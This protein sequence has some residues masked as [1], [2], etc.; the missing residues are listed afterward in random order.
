MYTYLYI[1]ITK[2]IYIYVYISIYITI[3]IYICI[4]IYIYTHTVCIHIYIVYHIHTVTHIY[5]YMY[6][7]YIHMIRGPF[8]FVSKKRNINFH[9]SHTGVL[10][11]WPISSSLT[12]HVHSHPP[13]NNRQSYIPLKI[14]SSLVITYTISDC[15]IPH[16]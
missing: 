1:C 16:S 9:I 12:V 13:T 8:S 14:I 7:S 4:H 11:I 3:Y 2:Y 15:C 6:V 5:I 10:P